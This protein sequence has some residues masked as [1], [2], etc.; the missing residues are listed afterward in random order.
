MDMLIAAL[1]R[2]E[3]Y[4]DQPAQVDILQT[5]ISALFFAGDVVYKVKKP[6]DLGFVDYSTL[7]RRKHFCEEELRLNR[8]LAALAP[9]GGVYL[10]V[11]TIV[12][13]SAGRIGVRD[14]E[15]HEGE[16]V[17]EYAVRMT[18]LPY[19]RM[20]SELLARGEVDNQQMRS[21]A[22]LLVSFHDRCDS[23]PA[24]SQHASVAALQCQSSENFQLLDRF[25]GDNSPGTCTLSVRLHHHLQQWCKAF[26][27]DHVSTF[28]QRVSQRRIREGHGDLHA[29]NICVLPDR[30]V[31]YD[32]IEFTPRFR[33]RD[34]A[35]ELAFLAMDLDYRGF[36]GFAAYL[37][38]QYAEMARDLDLHRLTTYYK[39]H[40]A[41]VRGK[42][43]SLRA[44]D[45]S[46][47][48]A[49]R[50]AAVQEARSYFYLAATYTLASRPIMIMM[51]GLP[52]SG[53][54][55]AAGAI[56]RPFEAVVL[57]SDVIR[58]E[59]AGVPLRRLAA[60]EQPPNLYEPEFSRQTYEEM[61][62][63]A[64]AALK[65]GRT[66][67]L[68]AMFSQAAHRRAFIHLAAALDASVLIVELE[69]DDQTIRQ[70]MLA[71]KGVAG[72]VSDADWTVYQQARASFQP[73]H[74]IPSSQRVAIPSGC[75]VDVTVSRVI[76]ALV[77]QHG[78]T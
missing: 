57:R 52:G 69:A 42:V 5:H 73:P 37:L 31:I 68:D 60:H 8:R 50:A 15:V 39:A 67:V 7:A 76:D 58:K 28:E 29:G 65:A 33:C 21:I 19:D 14:D 48:E 27:R 77:A 1:A 43:A 20:L 11:S 62:R 24:V 12:Q 41:V 40:L 59:L 61:L 13:D 78:Q 47:A 36:R 9:G 25:A 26:L 35:C 49:D 46:I 6:V 2:P 34:V 70:R 32:C 44:V 54:S 4:P 3:V 22:A 53:K 16:T 30:I 72:E 64:D 74:E 38:H 75:E 66:V 18:R 23:G 51:C 17:I 71:R 63:R 45:Q 10:G 55:T 56:A